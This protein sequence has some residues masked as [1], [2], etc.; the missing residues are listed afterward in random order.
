MRF[1]RLSDSRF[2]REFNGGYGLLYDGRW[3]TRG[4]PVTY[5]ST[6]PSLSALEKRVHF[7]DPD[8]LPSQMMVEYEAPDDLQK[9]EVRQEALSQDWVRQ[10]TETRRIGDLWLGSGSTALLVIPS[11]IMA[12]EAA[13]DRNLLVNHRHRDTAVIRIV[14]A[15]PFTLDPRLFAG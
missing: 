9:Y 8:L 2:A 10:V 7:S 11:A 14:D 3:S 12:I 15:V 4:R 1:W 6:V 5:C 13:P